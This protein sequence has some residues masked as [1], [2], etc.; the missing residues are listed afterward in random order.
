LDE[1]ALDWETVDERGIGYVRA[2]EAF[3]R[4]QRFVPERQQP[5]VYLPDLD[6]CGIPDVEGTVTL[7]LGQFPT[8]QTIAVTIDRKCTADVHRVY[9]VQ[10]ACYTWPGRVYADGTPAAPR[11]RVLVQLKKDGTYAWFRD[12]TPDAAP[13]FR[14]TDYAAFEA[15]CILAA[16]K[17]A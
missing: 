5:I 2:W 3:C 7:E 17:D 11:L 13:V 9:G 8:P 16:W 10:L 14:G 15:A 6:V 1:G 4:D 12:G